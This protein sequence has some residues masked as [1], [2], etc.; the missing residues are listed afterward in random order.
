[1]A[2]IKTMSLAHQYRLAKKHFEVI[3]IDPI[4]KNRNKKRLR[5]K[6]LFPPNTDA[7]LRSYGIPTVK[8]FLAKNKEDLRNFT[9]K[10]KFPVVLKIFSP[11]IIHK[12]ETGGIKI[13]LKNLEETEKAYD[14]IL[15][16][17]KLKVPQVNILGITISPMITEGKEIILGMKRDLIYGPVIMFGLGGI[18]V[19]ILKDVSFRVAP[20]SREDAYEMI[21]EI[22]SS[23][24]LL[25]ARGEKPS[26]IDAI[27]DLILKLSQ[28]SLDYPEISEIDLNPVKVFEKGRGC[29]CLDARMTTSLT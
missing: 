6:P 22:K 9:K 8:T 19:E 3:E 14:E 27:A 1:V 13:N 29:L 16:N 10:T 17:V 11:D 7:V 24:L 5:Q 26:D 18:Y 21:S 28:L 2:T 20:I 4:V 25:G 12:T 23:P 15:K